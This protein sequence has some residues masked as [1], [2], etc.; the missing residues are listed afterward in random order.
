MGLLLRQ[1]G[2]NPDKSDNEGRTPLSY[3]AEGGYEGV[4][5]MLLA[6]E[7][8]DLINQIMKG[9]HRSPIRPRQEV[10]E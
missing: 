8:V 9:E 1:G 2:D 3:T 7:E 10:R 6:R 5:K 4:M